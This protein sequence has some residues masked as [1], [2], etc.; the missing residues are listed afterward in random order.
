MSPVFQFM[1]STVYCISVNRL[2]VSGQGVSAKNPA[3]DLF[4]SEDSV[5]HEPNFIREETFVE[6]GHVE[7]IIA[8]DFS[9]Q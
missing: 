7:D 3:L 9:S 6:D 5:H 4:T 8:V 1:C 2:T